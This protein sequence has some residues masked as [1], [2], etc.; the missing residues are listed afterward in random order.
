MPSRAWPGPPAD[1]RGRSPGHPGHPAASA[2]EAAAPRRDPVLRGA[3]GHRVVRLRRVRRGRV[4]PALADTLLAD[5]ERAE[6]GPARR[7]RAPAGHRQPAEPR[8]R[9][10]QGDPLDRQG[11]GDL[12]RGQALPDQQRRGHQGGRA[13]LPAGPAPRRLRAG[14][15]DDRG[16]V[17]QERATG[18]VAPHDLREAPRGG[19]RLPALAQVVQGKDHHRLPEHDLLRQRRIRHRGG[20]ADLLRARSQ[21]P[22]VRHARPRAVRAAAA[23]VGGRAAGRHHPVADR[24]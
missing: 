2:S 18:A 20:G 19:A 21:P 8:D 6:L 12:D 22:G 17:H 23:A 13:R 5:Q 3:A 7:P 4:R 11:G 9:H 16:A 15:L 14:R 1:E 24:L 10:P